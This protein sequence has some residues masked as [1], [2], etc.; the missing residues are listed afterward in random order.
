MKRELVFRIADANDQS[1]AGGK[2]FSLAQMVQAG[3]SIPPG[4]VIS[5]QAHGLMTDDLQR[6]LYNEYDAL[7]MD[8]V[9]VRSSAVNE[10][11]RDAAWA[12][13]FDTFLNTT[14]NELIKNIELCWKS[15][16]TPRAQSYALQKSLESGR[17]AVIIQAMIQSHISGVA[18]SVHPVV[19]DKTKI[20]IE[21]GYGLGEAI[22]SGQITPD[23]YIFDKATGKVISKHIHPQDKKLT[24]STT[25][26]T[27]WSIISAEKDRQK[28]SDEQI[29]QLGDT[30]HRLEAFFGFPVDVEWAVYN[31]QLYI[32]QCRPITVLAN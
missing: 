4:F 10:D 19:N 17:V 20:I 8:F 30:V 11:G 2:A 31:D 5:S 25:G 27:T 3:F 9:A 14:R 24:K 28:L 1:L 32:L 12:G 16:M 15:V 21:A 18:F 22:V 23:Q 6:A 26:E 29:R 7:A 13:Q